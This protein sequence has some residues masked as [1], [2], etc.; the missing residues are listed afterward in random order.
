MKFLSLQ[1][2][3]PKGI[4]ECLIQTVS[5]KFSSYS[6][7]KKWYDNFQRRHFETHVTALSKVSA[8]EIVGHVHDLNYELS[9][10]RL[11]FIIDEQLN[12]EQL[13]V[14][15]LNGNQ[16]DIEGKPPS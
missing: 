3:V 2:K 6:T 14:N 15:N 11:R 9:R 7:E 16:R 8:P 5:D 13:L 1:K 12:D 10:K 4:Q